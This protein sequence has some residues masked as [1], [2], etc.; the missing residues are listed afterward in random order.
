MIQE[1]SSPLRVP[2]DK[3]FREQIEAGFGSE[4]EMEC[5]CGLIRRHLEQTV[6]PAGERPALFE[7][8]THWGAGVCHFHAIAPELEIHSL[9]VLP[10]D[11]T[12][13]PRQMAS[14]I[15][16]E[17]HIGRFARERGISYT[18]HFGNSRTFDWDGM[19]ARRRFDIVFVD[20]CHEQLTVLADTLNALKILKPGGLIIWHDCKAVD[21]PGREALTALLDLNDHE[22][23]GTIRHVENTWLAYAHW[24][25]QVQVQAQAEDA[26][27]AS[28]RTV[29]EEMQHFLGDE[30]RASLPEKVQTLPE[31]PEV[32]FF[33]NHRHPVWPP[34][35]E[36]AG[37]LWSA[38]ATRDPARV[39]QAD[40]VV[41]HLPDAPAWAQL[42]KAPH[43]LWVGV[44]MEGDA[45]HPAQADPGAVS[46]LDL[47]ISYH[48][49]ADVR[50]NFAA[51]GTLT[52]VLKP[53]PAKDAGNAVCAFVSNPNSRCG[54]ERVLERLE[55][56]MPVHH[57]GAWHFNRPEPLREGRE[58]RL[59]VLSRY[60]FCLAFEDC[61]QTDYVT[62]QWYD[63]FA[64]GCVP[65]YFG[66]LGVA[67]YAPGPGS[68]LQVGS[69]R[70]LPDLVRQMREAARNSER[71][72]QFFQ[73]KHA[74]AKSFG[75]LCTNRWNAFSLLAK[76][77]RVVQETRGK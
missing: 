67:R 31:I 18:Q 45:R 12:K 10:S 70:D 69:L 15:V 50:L 76:I 43:Q 59:E 74:P 65:V 51:P 20:G 71:Y 62:E 7:I 63:C 8:G 28:P 2:Y 19:A 37:S 72:A 66:G 75:E 4:R 58:A 25:P 23:R 64:A 9:N 60:H 5:L 33:S 26:L 46:S 47:L 77:E 49:W 34:A 32:L 30:R 24:P 13:L 42:P 54:R 11:L 3:P 68:Y 44:T 52:E 41:F 61:Q 55:S 39:T 21:A 53:V 35:Q 6:L 22:F 56:L 40:V 29:Q 17:K 36:L 14:E 57:F 27:P 48:A 1:L 16:Q 38:R 73:W